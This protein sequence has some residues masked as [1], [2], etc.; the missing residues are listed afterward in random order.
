VAH[1]RLLQTIAAVKKKNDRI[2]CQHD[3]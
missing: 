2:G 3:L 1:A